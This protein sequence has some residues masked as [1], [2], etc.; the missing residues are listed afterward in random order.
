MGSSDTCYGWVA[1]R[2]LRPQCCCALPVGALI[3][4]GTTAAPRRGSDSLQLSA[5][6]AR[7]ALRKSCLMAAAKRLVRLAMLE[8]TTSAKPLHLG[9]VENG[10][11]N[12]PTIV[13]FVCPRAEAITLSRI[14]VRAHA[15]VA[16]SP[17]WVCKSIFEIA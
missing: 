11:L 15:K 2:I 5:A 10:Y 4:R 16:I 12:S 6:Q 14:N 8:D 1:I 3:A 13:P 7:D 17:N 9:W